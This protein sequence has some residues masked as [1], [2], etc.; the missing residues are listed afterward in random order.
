MRLRTVSV[1][2]G[3]VLAC[4][5]GA[6]AQYRNGQA[7]SQSAAPRPGPPRAPAGEA[8]YRNTATFRP[9]PISPSLGLPIRFPVV[10][11]YWGWGTMPFYYGPEST[12][13][14]LEDGPIGGVQLDVQPWRAAVFVDGVY[15]GRV[16][17]YRGYYKHLELVAGPHQIV[18]V[19]SGYQPLVID[20]Y[21]V[22]GETTTYRG[23]LSNALRW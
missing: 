20:A 23:T 16:D 14:A 15:A 6:D 1:V 10:P 21:V 18:V 9:R 11:V 8:P 5:V 19:E 4:G 12:P 3:L 22:P 2:V 13:F 7:R 17:D